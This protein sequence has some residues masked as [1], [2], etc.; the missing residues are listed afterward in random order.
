MEEVSPPA[1][2]ADAQIL[3]RCAI[4]RA[5]EPA[6]LVSLQVDISTVRTRECRDA[7]GALLVDG[8]T[9][10]DPSSALPA[11][12]AGDVARLCG[13]SSKA[14]PLAGLADYVAAAQYWMS[15]A[16]SDLETIGDYRSRTRLGNW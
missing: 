14:I 9:I 13:P 2:D 10:G 12:I 6:L 4:M 16:M 3:P 1:A 5:E 7:E 15:A 8:V 11:L